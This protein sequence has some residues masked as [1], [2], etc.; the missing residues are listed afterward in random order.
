MWKKM[1]IALLILWLGTIGYTGYKIK[2]GN[3][4]IVDKRMEINLKPEEREL[5]L[6]EMR[7]LLKGLKG[8]IKGLSEDNFK[9]VEISARGNG[10]AMAQDINPALISKLPLTFKKMGMKVHKEFDELANKVH[11][12][13]QK[14]ILKKVDNIMSYCVTVLPAI[15]LIKLTK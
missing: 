2:Y 11:G 15:K 3:A 13:D 9:V 8:I 12:M 7:I 6:E 4:V 5:V 10:M 1:T 14:T